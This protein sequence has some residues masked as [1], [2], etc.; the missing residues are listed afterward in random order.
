[1]DSQIR[2]AIDTKP[3]PIDVMD[4]TEF[5]VVLLRVQKAKS[6]DWHQRQQAL[7]LQVLSAS[8]EQLKNEADSDVQ[9]VEDSFITVIII[10]MCLL[11]QNYN[12][13]L[14]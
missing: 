12:W 6:E 7:R 14:V 2:T 11:L 1:M 3:L 10:I 4:I 13:Q 9:N 8:F 5:R